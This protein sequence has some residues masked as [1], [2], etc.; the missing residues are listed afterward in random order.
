LF[1]WL[2]A[3]QAKG[4][5]YL[6]IEDTDKAREVEGSEQHI[7]ECLEWLGIDWD[8]EIIKQS[9]RLEIYKEWAQKL[10]DSGRAYADPYSPQEL[11]GFRQEAKRQK[12][13]F[14]FRDHRPVDP[15]KW[16]GTRPLRFKSDPKSYKWRDEVMGELQ[17]G[18]EVV[19][20]F[21]IL[22]TD[23]YPTYNFAHVVD[24]HLME[25][26]HVIRTQEFLPSVPKFLNLYEALEI[27]RPALTTLPY[28]MGPDG[29][30]KLSKRDGAKDILD[31]KKDG[32]LPEA[33]VNLLATLGW[34]DGT[35]QEIYSRDELLQ[36]FSLDRVQKSGARFDEKR[37]EWMNG[38]Y[39]RQK[40]LG[41]LYGLSEAFWPPSAKDKPD[42]YK[43]KVLGLVQERLKHLSELP[44]LTGFFFEE[45]PVKLELI[46]DNKQ[47]AKL[48]REG[49]RGL[50]QK[51]LEK[52]QGID[53][54]SEQ[55][56]GALNN[57]L[58]ETGQKPG[59]LFSMIRIA[60]TWAPASPGLAD[61]LALL[62]KDE[63]LKRLQR[64]ISA[65]E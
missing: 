53:F 40:P 64:A 15:P 21:I 29:K 60:T 52:L 42:D 38:H 35:D 47:L 57:L 19:D 1:A 44:L 51:A 61:T 3:N 7:L 59:V 46:E 36:K 41:E 48:G 62:G 27:N 25:I 8:G 23:G 11:E 2:V 6:R 28:V 18:P 39:I 24:D 49:Q 54:S 31:Y 14:L 32:Y 4:Q 37:L 45:L 20:D 65:L 55:L 26:T 9:Q 33:L 43:K 58:E 12:K 5:F 34:N 63:V 50:L 30:K 22:K 56:T 17:T 16:D 10:V 13:P